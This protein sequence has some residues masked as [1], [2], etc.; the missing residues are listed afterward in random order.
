MNSP[1]PVDVVDL[2]PGERGSLLALLSDLSDEEWGKPTI[3][4]GWSV[5]DVALHLL[6]DDI[7]ILSGKRDRFRNPSFAP[8]DADLARW[9]ELVKYLNQANEV[10][11]QATRRISPR[12]LC[13][14]LGFTGEATNAYFRDRDPNALGGP[15]TWAGPDPAPAWLDTA[16]EY[17]ER[18][19]HQQ[20]IRDALGRP[21]LKER[22]WLGPV[23]ETFVRALPHTLRNV[24]APDGT[25]LH[26]VIEG[27]AGGDWY[28]VRVNEVWAL[29]E[30]LVTSQ[31]AVVR[32]DQESAWRLFTKATTKEEVM[33]RARLE[34]DL[35]LAEKALEMVSIIA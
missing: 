8:A 5:K 7:N 34:G 30:D 24:D 22:R 31:K 20:Q 26:L 23:L 12:L 13:E 3:C 4:T 15:V 11:V 9:S 18:W 25:C 28:A 19:V 35:I 17:T 14:L 33:R 2:F 32:L 16:R 29:T 1:D 27:E 6:G 10:W 21:G